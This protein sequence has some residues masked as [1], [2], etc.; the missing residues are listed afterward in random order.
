MGLLRRV[1]RIV[2]GFMYIDMY[3]HTHRKGLGSE[4]FGE[5]TWNRR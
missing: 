2:Y 3:I 4:S 5:S 1:L